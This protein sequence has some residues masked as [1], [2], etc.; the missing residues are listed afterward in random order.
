[1]FEKIFELIN[2]YSQANYRTSLE[3]Y[4]SIALDYQT[5]ELETKNSIINKNIKNGKENE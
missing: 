3:I 5:L 4:Q 1:M 2:D